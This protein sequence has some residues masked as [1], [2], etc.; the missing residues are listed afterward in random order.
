MVYFL[1]EYADQPLTPRPGEIR[2]IQV[3]PFE[4]ALRLFDHE[5][6]K[7]VLRAAHAF[8]NQ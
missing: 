4:E 6:A 1:A 3:L 8:L 5:G 7:N 2:E